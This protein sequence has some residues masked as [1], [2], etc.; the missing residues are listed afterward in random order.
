MLVEDAHWAIDLIGSSEPTLD[1]DVIGL[2]F[3][4]HFVRTIDEGRIT[5]DSDD[6]PPGFPDIAHP[7][8][9]AYPEIDARSPSEPRDGWLQEVAQRR[10]SPQWPERQPRVA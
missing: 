8:R 3:A 2:T 1:M 4:R 5:L 7:L 9:N 6:V 10:P